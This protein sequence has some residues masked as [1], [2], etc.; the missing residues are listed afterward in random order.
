MPLFLKGLVIT[1]EISALAS[2]AALIWGL[3]LLLLRISKRKIFSLPAMGYIELV[4]NV[5]V[6]IQMY[7][8]YFGLPSVGIVFSSFVCGVLALTIQNGGYLA[9][10]YRGGIEA[11][12]STQYE[13]GL[14]L[15]MRRPLIMRKIILPQALKS[16]I[17]PVVNQLIILLKDSSLA[18][19][20]AVMEITHVGKLLT[21]RSGAT[22]EV[23]ITIAIFYIVVNSILS[24]V[25]NLYEKRVRVIR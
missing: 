8:I 24:L 11:I 2:A 20:I 13:S 22:Y 6:L 10:I 7:I 14:A 25:L 23:F 16:V 1:I 3:V 19:S 4:R 5:P 17:P 9:E 15:G 18:S 21:E 12:S